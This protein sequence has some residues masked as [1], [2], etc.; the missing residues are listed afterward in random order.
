M[1]ERISFRQVGREHP[2]RLYKGPNQDAYTRVSQPSIPCKED[3][4][5]K[6]QDSGYDGFGHRGPRFLRLGNNVPG[7]GQYQSLPASHSSS[8]SLSKKGFLAGFVSSTKRFK[9][10]QFATI[11]PGPGSYAPSHRRADS[12][13]SPAFVKPKA[14]SRKPKVSSPAPGQYD[15]PSEQHFAAGPSSVFRSTTKRSDNAFPSQAPAPWFY[16]PDE[17]LVRSSSQ[18]LTS[19]FKRPVNGKR[20]KINLYDPHAHVAEDEGPGPGHYTVQN[21]FEKEKLNVSYSHQELDR[22][23]QSIRSKRVQPVVPGPGAYNTPVLSPEK[24]PVSGA[25][26]MSESQREFVKPTKVPGPAFYR[27]AISNKKKSFLLNPANK[28]V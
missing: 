5:L 3:V 9:P 12:N 4:V 20:F 1:A 17:H 11:A 16:S 28:W 6:K 13:P 7:P 26:F 25:V 14:Q 2:G 19:A 23:G 8:P 18:E 27:P 22:F 24:Q 15:T 21:S 10:R